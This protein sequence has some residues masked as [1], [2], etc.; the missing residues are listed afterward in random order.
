MNILQKDHNKNDKDEEDHQKIKDDKNDRDNKDGVHLN[1][2]AALEVDELQ[3]WTEPGQ[4]KQGLVTNMQ[5][6]LG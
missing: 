5:T 3:L 4:V 1:V 2:P 6:T